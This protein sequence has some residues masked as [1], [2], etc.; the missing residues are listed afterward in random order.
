MLSDE[1]LMFSVPNTINIK[2]IRFSMSN[3]SKMVTLKLFVYCFDKIN[4]SV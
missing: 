2:L 3:V 1:I 4:G